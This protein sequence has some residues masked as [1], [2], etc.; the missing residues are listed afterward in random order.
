MMDLSE[1]VISKIYEFMDFH[2]PQKLSIELS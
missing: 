1:I 2:R